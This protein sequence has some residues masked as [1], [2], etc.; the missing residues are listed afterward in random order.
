MTKT[1]L[2][3]LMEKVDKKKTPKHWTSFIIKNVVKH[4]LIL[5]Y[6]KKAFCTYCQ[7]YFDRNVSINEEVECPYCKN[8]YYVRNQNVRNEFFLKDIAFYT[9]ID[10]HV[11]LRIFEIKSY[12]D[13]TIR[14]FHQDLQ[15]FARFIPNVGIIINNSVSFYMWHQKVWHNIPITNWHIYTGK[16]L[17]YDMPIYP[18]NK[19]KL[20]KDTCLQYAPIEEFRK[21]YPGYTQFQVMQLATYQSFELLWKMGLYQLAKVPQ[22]FNKKG[23]FNKR[24]GVPKSFLKF[25]QD[26]NI[27]WEEYMLLKLL[28]KP[29]MTIIRKYYFFRY[30]YLVF[31][32]K[33]GLLYDYETVNQFK[34]DF[35]I[36]KEICEYVPLRKFLQYEKGIKNMQIYADYLRM[37]TDLGVNI[38]SKKRLFPYQLVAWHD[39]FSEKM[40]IVGDS[41]T[42]FKV[43]IRFLELSRNIYKDDKYIIFPVPSFEDLVDEGKQQGNCVA[44]Y[45]QRYIKKETEIYFIRELSNPANSLITLEYKNNRI[46]QMEL[47]HHKR[48]FTSEQLEFV[49]KWKG[50]RS[51][52]KYKEKYKS[53]VIEH[54]L[55]KMA[56]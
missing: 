24:F 36:L 47:P 10:G 43:Y 23:N 21:A 4:N 52:A 9:K 32:K 30:D 41:L 29:D 38:K 54:N 28:Q 35:E 20:F 2:Q 48:N 12:Y 13:Y 39:K 19:K 18:H 46:K 56:A 26:N 16:K 49:E 50:H 7:K 40:K 8:K 45:L 55:K 6:G 37:A 14:A 15:E 34:Y 22:K 25:M 44:S 17:I 31:M 53:K 5:K 3:E 42:Q 1:N 51:F 27:S 11:I 33:Q